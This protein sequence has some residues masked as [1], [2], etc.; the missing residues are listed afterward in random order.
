MKNIFIALLLIAILSSCSRKLN[1]AIGYQQI[2]LQPKAINIDELGKRKLN[3]IPLG[4]FQKNSLN[5]EDS[6]LIYKDGIYSN[7]KIFSFKALPSRTYTVK[8]NSQ[9]DCGGFK[10]YLFNPEIRIINDHGDLIESKIDTS[11]FGINNSP[12]FL[13]KSW[14]VRTD[15]ETNCNVILYS[16]NE[17]LGEDVY[18]IVATTV[19]YTGGIFI[20]LAIPISIKSTLI[21][22]FVILVKSSP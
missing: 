10:K 6:I 8:V 4:R 7:Y 17:A 15:E 1:P 14:I 21:G 18:N 9:C 12:M 16:N 19:V 3:A 22:D 20:P 5:L 2:K 11:Y 13:N